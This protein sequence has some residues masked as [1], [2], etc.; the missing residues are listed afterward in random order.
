[1]LC[2][3]LYTCISLTDRTC[4][5]AMISLPKAGPRK[6]TVAAQDV[7]DWRMKSIAEH[8]SSRVRRQ[9]WLDRSALDGACAISRGSFV[10]DFSGLRS[11]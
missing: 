7:D 1:M 9:R 5:S 4:R 3:L 10:Q 2:L 11:V 8:A 6:C